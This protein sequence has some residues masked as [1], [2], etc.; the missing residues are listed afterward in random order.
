MH[1]GVYLGFRNKQKP[2]KKQNSE[3]A[4]KQRSKEAGKGRKSEKQKGEKQNSW[5]AGNGGKAEKQKAE[6][7]RSTETEIQKKK[8]GKE[9]HRKHG[10]PYIN[11]NK[12]PILTLYWIH[13]Q[14]SP[15]R[16]V[17]TF[18]WM[19]SAKARLKGSC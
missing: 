8:N 13:G 4:E 6:K 7:Q 17:V 10:P 2:A 14:I 18:C 3:E 1:V 5:E 12:H 9:K 11:L 16:K 19:S 15:G